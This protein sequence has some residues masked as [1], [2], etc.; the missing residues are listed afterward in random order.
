LRSSMGFGKVTY[1]SRKVRYVSI[2]IVNTMK[3]VN[4]FILKFRVYN[5]I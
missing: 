1:V 2:I 4:S 5:R 3:I